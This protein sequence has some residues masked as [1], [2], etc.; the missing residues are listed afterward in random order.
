DSEDGSIADIKV[1]TD[2]LVAV[3]AR[4]N[5]G[6]KENQDNDYLDLTDKEI[7]TKNYTKCITCKNLIKCQM[8]KEFMDYIGNTT[9]LRHIIP[10]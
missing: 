1:T 3:E 10:K 4:L 6:L 5:E 8:F 9:I 2:Y 7:K